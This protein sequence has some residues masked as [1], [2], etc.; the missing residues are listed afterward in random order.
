MIKKVKITQVFKSDKKPDGTPRAYAKG[1]N[2]GKPF[3]IIGIKTDKTGEEIYNTNAM[4]G[5]KAMNIEVG[6]S[7]LLNFTETKSEDGQKIWKNFNFPTKVQLAEYA[8]S[9]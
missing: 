4:V 3:T 2:I 5:E 8:E 1:T 7:L 6:Q 9:I